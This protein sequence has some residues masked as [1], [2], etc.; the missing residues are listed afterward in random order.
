M[1]IRIK[2]KSLQG[3]IEVIASKSLSHRYVIAAAL[4]NEKCVI[5]NV[6]KSKDLEATK[7]ALAALGASF[8]EDIIY[9]ADLNLRAQKVNVFESGSTLRFMIPIFMLQTNEIEVNGM[10]R[11]ID[12]PLDVYD[13]LFEHKKVVFKHL[14][15]NHQLPVL[16]KGKIK[17]GHFP[18]RGDVSSQFISGLLFALPLTGRDSVIE[19]TSPLE[20]KGYVDLT[21]DV[22]RKFGIHIL[23]VDQ[24]IYIKGGQK[25][26]ARDAIVEGDFSQSAFWFVAG[27]IGD[28][29]LVL[30]HLKQDSL[31][32]DKE[33]VD[34][35][36]RMHADIE[37]KNGNYIVNPSK[38]TG[39]TIDLSQVPDLGPMLMGLAGVSEG[40]TTFIN[41]E[42]LRI[43][44]SD[45]VEAMKD[46]LSRFGVEMKEFHDKIEIEGKPQLKGNIEI[47]TFNDHRIAMAA[48][49]LAI[50][51]KGD[52]VIKG[53]ECVEK[54][55]PIF[56][57]VYKKVG[58]DVDEIR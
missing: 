43:K 30:K 36:K 35:L 6:L 21:L 33:I 39:T 50:R 14:D 12:R 57:E 15:S 28:H 51:A 11:L 52:V 41:Y 56:F 27:L 20:S 10:N 23:R 13:R 22:L 3:E 18:L 32:G 42:R 46:V 2:P 19:L 49:V 24:Y 58:G 7:N 45:R 8:D 40:T 37:Y 34:I 38:T 5:S 55:Y 26:Q 25:Y 48:S 44:E 9:P 17:G 29:Q 16:I 1:D 47:D 4:S 53:A 31:Q 54:S